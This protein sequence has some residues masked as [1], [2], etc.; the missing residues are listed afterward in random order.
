LSGLQRVVLGGVL[1]AGALGYLRAYLANRSLWHDEALLALELIDRNSLLEPFQRGQAVPVG[2]AALTSAAIYLFG[3]ASEHALRLWSVVAAVFV[4]PAVYLA[5]RQVVSRWPAI[6][7]TAIVATA[8]SLLYFSSEFKPYALDVFFSAAILAAAGQHLRTGCR[9]RTLW[10]FTALSAVAVWVSYPSIIVIAAACLAMV[11]WS[12]GRQWSGIRPLALAIAAVGVSFVGAYAISRRL[13][14]DVSDLQTYWNGSFLPLPPR[15]FN[16]LVVWLS[17]ALALFSEPFTAP[18][19]DGDAATQATLLVLALW[20][21]GVVCAWCRDRWSAILLATPLAAT[22][23]IAALHLY[24]ASGRLIL[25]LLPV[26]AIGTSAAVEALTARA[27]WAA[28]F[29]S[30]LLLV[31]PTLSF[32]QMARHPSGREDVRGALAAL[33]RQVQRGDVVYLFAR[34]VP[35]TDYYRRVGMLPP[36]EGVAVMG[37]KSHHGTPS[38]YFRELCALAGRERIWLL[39]PDALGTDRQNEREFLVATLR[40]V[41]AVTR[42]FSFQRASLYLLDFSKSR[43]R[44]ACGE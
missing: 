1:I 20:F 26:V 35:T 34:A 24:P 43:I 28:L 16:D 40:G 29:T 38:G 37:G 32:L 22:L 21:G 19:N 8:P 44:R 7:A 11:S 6:L 27:L 41:D 15:S 9:A 36:R 10:M 17:R 42:E 4:P 31:L 14:A 13:V 3:S 23:A 2:F 25:F 12:R 18:I 39:M 30:V 33:D 5:A